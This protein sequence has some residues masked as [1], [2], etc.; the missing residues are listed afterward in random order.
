MMELRKHTSSYHKAEK[1]AN[2]IW[3]GIASPYMGIDDIRWFLK[4][5]GSMEEYI[6]LNQQLFDELMT[7]DV[8]DFGMEYEMPVGFITGAQ[9]WT[10]PVKYAKD[11][12]EAI[13]A[14]EKKLTLIDGCGHLPQ[15]DD[16]EA[17]C[18][19]LKRMLGEM[20]G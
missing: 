10:T 19:E 7:V 5:L 3:T 18:N 4:Q 20:L 6:K 2:T 13:T 11:Y 9:D 17:F 15:Y 16:P 8:R 1:S 14:P 12:C